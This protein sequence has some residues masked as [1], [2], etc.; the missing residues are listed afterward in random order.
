M[1]L[2]VKNVLFVGITIFITIKAYKHFKND[3]V[4]HIIPD[5]TKE[6]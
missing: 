5:N 1:N 2:S 6:G 3:Y 4:S